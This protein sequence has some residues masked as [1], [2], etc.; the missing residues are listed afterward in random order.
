M[1][2]TPLVVGVDVKVGAVSTGPM[3]FVVIVEVPKPGLFTA[4]LAVTRAIMNLPC[5]AGVSVTDETLLL[6]VVTTGQLAAQVAVSQAK[7]A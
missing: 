5:N 7:N 1:V 4:T 3:A 6:A 2:A